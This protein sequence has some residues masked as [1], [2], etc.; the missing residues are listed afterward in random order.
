MKGSR[1]IGNDYI[2]L[3]RLDTVQCSRL[4]VFKRIWE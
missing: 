4:V 2:L 3:D 1:D